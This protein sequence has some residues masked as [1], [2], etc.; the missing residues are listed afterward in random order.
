MR[1]MPTADGWSAWDS[2][3]ASAL[4]GRAASITGKQTA[5]VLAHVVG[6][7]ATMADLAMK[8]RA[9][10]VVQEHLPEKDEE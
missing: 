6:Q 5:E 3:F 9:K 2:F 8:E 10:R 4:E 7:A 1:Q